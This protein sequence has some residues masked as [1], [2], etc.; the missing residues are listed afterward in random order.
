MRVVGAA[1]AD[2]GRASRPRAHGT[3]RR[4]PRRGPGDRRRPGR[5][6]SDSSEP[7]VRAALAA[8]FG[9]DVIE[10]DGPLDRRRLG[11][12]VFSDAGGAARALDRHRPPGARG[13]AARAGWRCCARAGLAGVVVLDAALL[14]EW[15]MERECD[16]VVAR[17]RAIRRREQVRRLCARGAGARTES[18]AHRL[19]A[20][21]VPNDGV[22]RRGRRSRSRLRAAL[23]DVL[24]A[25]WTRAVLAATA[26]HRRGHGR[27][28]DRTRSPGTS[29]RC[30]V[31]ATLRLGGIFDVEPA[32]ARSP[33]ELEA[34]MAE[35]GFWDRPESSPTRRCAELAKA[36]RSRL[37]PCT[38][39]DAAS[40][41]AS[42]L[43]LLARDED[44]A[45][46]LAEV[47]RELNQLSRRST[48]WRR[49]ACSPAST[50]GWRPRHHPPR[51]RRHRVAGLGRDAVA[52]VHSAGA[53][54]TAST[55]RCSTCSRARR[56][57]SR[58]PRSRS[59]ASTPTATSR[60]RPACTGWCASRP[61][62]RRSAATPRSPRCSCIR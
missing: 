12:P 2:R 49:A 28:H 30:T 48:S 50:T 21:A 25:R 59:T 60:P 22:R 18:C 13:A 20:Q 9:A 26:R 56:P 6:R 14:L 15:G 5:A 35:P 41:D 55:S 24:A 19:A 8:E 38:A 44:D 4:P 61:S 52:H 43:L 34:R 31:R 45:A 36:L 40:C 37:E 62:T 11:A 54:A 53:S 32:P 42:E 23:A 39:P 27:M 33:D 58:T 47:A 10:P 29:S 46:V 7:A 16:A 1:G 57:A 51:R 17:R 3:W